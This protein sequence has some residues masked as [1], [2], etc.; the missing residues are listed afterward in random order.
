MHLT[1]TGLG[2]MCYVVSMQQNATRVLRTCLFSC[3]VN[4]PAMNG[5]VVPVV[6]PAGDGSGVPAARPGGSTGCGSDSAW[7][8]SVL[9]SHRVQQASAAQLD[10]ASS[11]CMQLEFLQACFLGS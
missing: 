6:S 5:A 7:Q 1:D 10:F 2:I 9:V 8:S 4:E 11:L 3:I